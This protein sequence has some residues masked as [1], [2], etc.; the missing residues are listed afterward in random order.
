MAH[1]RALLHNFC[2]CDFAKV[3]MDNITDTVGFAGILT[4]D[5]HTVRKFPVCCENDTQLVSD[6][7]NVVVFFLVPI[8]RAF[9]Q[10]IVICAFASTSS[11]TSCSTH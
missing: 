8:Q 3:T 9:L 6:E 10:T 2:L 7:R 5:F 1:I 4:D 11:R